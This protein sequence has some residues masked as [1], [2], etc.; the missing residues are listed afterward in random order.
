MFA[1]GFCWLLAICGCTFAYIEIPE[2]YLTA[3]RQDLAD[4]KAAG[5]YN[6]DEQGDDWTGTCQSGENQSPIDL[7]FEDSKI[8]AI[9]RLRFNNYD[10]PLQTPLVITN[11]GHTANMVIP[12]TRGGQRPSINGSLLPGNFEAQSVHFHWGSREAKGSEHAIEFQRYDVEM[13]IVHKNTI[14]ETMGEATMHP[15]G[16]AVLGV[17]FRAVDRQTSQHYGLNKIFNQ[18]PRIVQYNSNA[19]ITGRLTVG[20]LLGNI[21][22][23][24]FFTYNGSLTTPD[25]AEAVTWTVFPDVLDYPRRQ[26][27]KLW[28]LRDS[29]QRPL[30]NN[31]RSIQDTNSRDVYYRTIQ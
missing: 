27:T 29:R 12:Q 31:Y 13:H 25:C 14:Y 8:V 9:P 19:T 10:Q 3:I 6:Y 23:G 17:M 30:I 2:A 18:L 28:N 7:I 22:T 11:N 1:V 24:E 16:L 20:Q 5:E 21:V 4:E 15:D 26:I